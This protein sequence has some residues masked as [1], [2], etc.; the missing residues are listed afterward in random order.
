M[1][2][3][4][5]ELAKTIEREH[6]R[7]ALDDSVVRN[8]RRSP[9]CHLLSQSSAYDT[10]MT[11]VDTCVYRRWRV[12][13]CEVGQTGNKVGRG[14]DDVRGFF[15]LAHA[16]AKVSLPCTR[17]Q[18]R[19]HLL[20]CHASQRNLE[21]LALGVH[22]DGAHV[23]GFAVDEVV[24]VAVTLLDRGDRTWASLQLTDDEGYW[25]L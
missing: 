14:E 21:Y 18:V 17:G 5:Y 13:E 7:G 20:P 25:R 4:T 19:I 24:R 16:T 1:R 15:S 9:F 10:D 8:L 3:W 11:P 12:R 23:A 2:L 6:G 22:C